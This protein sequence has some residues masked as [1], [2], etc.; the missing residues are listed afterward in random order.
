MVG[1]SSGCVRS[2]GNC[3]QTLILH[4]VISLIFPPWKM[5]G[6]GI[7]WF[8]YYIH[9]GVHCTHIL[10]Y[11]SSV[12]TRV[13]M[14][15]LKAVKNIKC[16]KAQMLRVLCFYRITAFISTTIGVFIMTFTA[17]LKKQR[18][19]KKNVEKQKKFKEKWNNNNNERSDDVQRKNIWE[20][21]QRCLIAETLQYWMFNG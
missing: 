11:A 19:T 7:L 3:Y 1:A 2:L 17:M 10:L 20:S 6:G 4:F 8:L 21:C 18:K 13:V 12:P 9:Y 15:R 16:H 14:S 5:N